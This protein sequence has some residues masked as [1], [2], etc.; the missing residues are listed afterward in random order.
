MLPAVHHHGP[1]NVRLSFPTP[2][3]DMKDRSGHAESIGGGGYTLYVFLTDGVFLH[4]DAGLDFDIISL[5]QYVRMQ[6]FK[7]LVVDSFKKYAVVQYS[8]KF[9]SERDRIMT[10]VSKRTGR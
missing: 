5:L 7:N 4:C 6:S 1:I 2:T 10:L 8:N 9:P 3:I